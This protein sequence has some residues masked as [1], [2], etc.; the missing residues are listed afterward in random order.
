MET[1]ET[2][3][4]PPLMYSCTGLDIHVKAI[5]HFSLYKLVLNFNLSQTILNY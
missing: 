3:L 4:D 1:N 2:P 5:S